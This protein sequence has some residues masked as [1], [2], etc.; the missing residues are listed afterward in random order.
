M[1]LRLHAE[2]HSLALLFGWVPT[3]R[4]V[5]FA[6]WNP[7]S[8]QPVGREKAFPGPP[9]S[10]PLS[11]SFLDPKFLLSH[12]WPEGCKSF[13]PWSRLPPAVLGALTRPPITVR[14]AQL[15][16]PRHGRCQ[17]GAV[18]NGEDTHAALGR[19]SEA[20]NKSSLKA[21]CDVILFFIQGPSCSIRGLR[22]VLIMLSLSI[23]QPFS[24]LC[25]SFWP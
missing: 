7:T 25:P 12:T 15:H 10:D 5:A 19:Q 9:Q 11:L 14:N 13:I 18:V 2:Y 4:A 16:A 23:I 8:L 22:F 6:E 24:E 3:W 17:L 20:S 1:Q 21:A